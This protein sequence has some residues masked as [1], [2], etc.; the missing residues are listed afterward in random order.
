MN[1]IDYRVA[2]QFHESTSYFNDNSDGEETLQ[3]AMKPTEKD[4]QTRIKLDLPV[5]PDSHFRDLLLA[6]H[7]CR[8][9][10]NT[11]I[12]LKQLINILFSGYGIRD[13]IKV[14]N[15]EWLVHTVPSAGALFPLEFY[16]LV[17]H[18]E[19]L[20]PGIYH[21]L[22][23]TGELAYIQTEPVPI[24]LVIRF[25]LN[26]SW[27]AGASVIIIATSVIQRTLSKYL[28][29]GY[30]YI[31]LEAGHAFQNMNLMAAACNVGAV[32]I[33]AFFD[34]EIARLLKIVD[35]EELPIY[36]TVLGNRAEG[37]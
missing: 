20:S 17:L 9:F 26:Q 10:N 4:G 34:N 37:Y 35:G 19:G 21:Y 11:P 28:D 13:T 12:T 25:F 33:G 2:R 14:N 16:I 8:Q 1:K 30:R 32:N 24:Q 29:R 6:R 22:P 5:I 3:P 36:A 23:K 15:E 27:I 7:S 18:V 31:L